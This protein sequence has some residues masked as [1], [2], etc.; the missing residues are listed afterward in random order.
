M[1]GMKNKLLK[2]NQNKI[3]KFTKLLRKKLTDDG[4][5][6]SY[7]NG[8]SDQ[9]ILKD[10]RIC[11]D[12]EEVIHTPDQQMQAIL[13]FDTAERSFD[14]LYGDLEGHDMEDMIDDDDELVLCEDSIDDYED[15]EIVR[16][17]W[18]LNGCINITEAI[19]SAEEFKNY[20]IGLQQQGYE[21]A[22]PVE[23]DYGVLK[24]NDET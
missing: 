18:I 15:I 8:L 17:K 22:H 9:Q 14:I 3:Q 5:H 20:L 21:L 13:E 1:Q 23:D 4:C 16:G 7:V 2:T 12:C 10:F 11:A 19:A 6:R 24:K